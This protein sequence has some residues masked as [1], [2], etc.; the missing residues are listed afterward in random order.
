MQSGWISL[1]RKIKDSVVY[2]DA[3][4]LKLWIHCLLK[5]THAEYQQLVGN[6]AI[7]LNP[8]EF[9]T[10]RDALATEYNEGAKPK[11]VV[12]SRT[13]WR[14]MKLLEELQMLSIKSESKY[15]VISIVN[16]NDYQQ[17]VQQKSSKSPTDVQ[18]MSTNN[19][20]NNINN[21]NK[22]RK[23]VYDE[24]SIPYRLSN[25]LFKKIL[26]NN[27]NHR[28]PNLQTWSDDFRKLV[29][30]DKRDPKEIGEVIEFAQTDDF[31][32]V[33]ILSASKLRKQYD[34]LNI[35]RLAITNEKP[36]HPEPPKYKELGDREY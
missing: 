2:S 13:V 27:P 22:S 23:Q 12:T 9:I 1:H 3:E 24:H 26:E 30:I 29:E 34:A 31:W 32:K 14:W 33:N 19:N 36:R 18:Q 6:K 21:I 11:N 35:K 5:A 17:N 8:G 15:S 20:I 4:L 28:A 7:I 10:G 16:W 25:Y